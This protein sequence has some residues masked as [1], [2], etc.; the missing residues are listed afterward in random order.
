MLISQFSKASGL[1]VET[2]RFYIKKGL[3]APTRGQQVGENT[4]QRFSATDLTT[5]RM[6]RLQ[7]SLG[8]SLREIAELQAEYRD[9][10]RSAAR[11]CEVLNQQIA[12]LEEKRTAIDAALVFLRGKVE[13]IENGQ[14]DDAPQFA[15]LPC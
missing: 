1:P 7:Q 11:T 15:E 3:L 4:Y 14:P 5:A 2:I 6:I 12:R 10:A 8:Y 13:W 9:S